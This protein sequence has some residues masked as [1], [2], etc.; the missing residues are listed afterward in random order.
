MTPAHV[1]CLGTVRDLTKQCTWGAT[2]TLPHR[3]G[4]KSIS[5]S[6]EC[7]PAN[8]RYSFYI[9]SYVPGL[10]LRG[11]V[12]LTPSL[13]RAWIPLRQSWSARPDVPDSSRLVASAT[14]GHYGRICSSPHGLAQR[15]HL[16]A[17][18]MARRWGGAP[19]T[20]RFDSDSPLKEQKEKR[21]KENLKT[22]G[23]GW[24]L[25]NAN[26][27]QG[28]AGLLLPTQQKYRANAPLLG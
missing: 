24:G 5:D 4:I 8:R 25:I 20:R 18:G 15:R 26:L 14:R 27:R 9:L 12:Q 19:Q 2:A 6:G 28:P 10:Q 1:P 3:P 11:S 17:P 13:Q 16:I 21:K 7:P 23:L 22:K